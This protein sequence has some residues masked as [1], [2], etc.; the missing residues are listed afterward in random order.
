MMRS[1]HAKL[2]LIPEGKTRKFD[3]PPARII[4]TGADPESPV[5][6]LAAATGAE[7]ESLV[8]VALV[9]I[10]G[11]DPESLV[12]ERIA[13][14]GAVPESCAVAGSDGATAHTNATVPKTSVR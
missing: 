4:A 9:C 6:P 2:S 5:V 11:A 3:I 12:N 8:T 10:T 14:R 1:S 7:P 13:A